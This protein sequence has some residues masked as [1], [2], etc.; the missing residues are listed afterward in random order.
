MSKLEAPLKIDDRGRITIPKAIR[1]TLGIEGK[2][3]IVNV[4]IETVEDDD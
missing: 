3:A 4:T 1:E 2:E